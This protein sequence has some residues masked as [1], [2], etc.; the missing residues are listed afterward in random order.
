MRLGN[1]IAALVAAAI[2]ACAP[3]AL[4][5]EAPVALQ[6]ARDL[7][8]TARQARASGVPTLLAFTEA[9]CPYCIRARNEYLLPLQAGGR[10]GRKI[11][12]LEVDIHDNG[13]LRDFDGATTSPAA[14][15]R[16]YRVSRVPTVIVVGYDGAPLA[17][18]I[19][20]LLGEDFYQLALERAIDAAHLKLKN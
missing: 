9:G 3:R 1:L 14:L 10:Y 20:G 6:A 8:A 13:T 15:A 17:N 11:V 4:G 12:I 16:R 5:A 7:S 18:P 19:V 2:L